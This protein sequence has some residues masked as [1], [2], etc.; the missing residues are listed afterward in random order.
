[1][2]KMFFL[3]LV[4]GSFSSLEGIAR[5]WEEVFNEDGIKVSQKNVEGSSIISFK[6]EVIAEKNIH[7]LFTVLYD[8]DH[9]EDFLQNVIEFRTLKVLNDYEGISYVKVGNNLPF[10]D[11]RDVILYSKI[12]LRPK[13]KQIYVSTRNSDLLLV[14]D[15]EGTVRIPKLRS[16]WLFEALSN[17]QT[18]VTY[19]NEVDPGGF[20]PK[21]IVN[22]ASKRLPFGTLQKLRKLSEKKEALKRT[23]TFLKYFIN[24]E[25]YLGKNHSAS[26]RSK[27]E[28]L[29]IQAEMRGIFKQHCEAG[30]KDSCAASKNYV[31]PFLRG[32][33]F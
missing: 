12:V 10:I 19:Q 16:S 11:N 33:G 22:L 13:D 30:S 18:R 17:T 8:P 2:K 31:V 29:S 1:M 4:F 14:P 27:E 20:I 21:W 25:P 15:Y 26:K 32:K 23:S 24:W 9:K 6:G 3:F 7:E 28:A 5:E